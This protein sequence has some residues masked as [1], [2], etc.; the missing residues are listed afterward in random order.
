MRSNLRSIFFVVFGLNIFTCGELCGTFLW[1]RF[2]C[3][4]FCLT[5][6]KSLWLKFSWSLIL[7]SAVWTLIQTVMREKL[8][9]IFAHK[10]IYFLL[11]RQTGFERFYLVWAIQ[12]KI[13]GH[14]QDIKCLW[15]L[16]DSTWDLPGLEI[17]GVTD[18]I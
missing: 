3:S 2:E 15:L 12:S 5:Q 10:K 13:S 17:R 7:I 1:L 14:G 6:T 4:L 9:T 11:C 18:L 8:P 16:I